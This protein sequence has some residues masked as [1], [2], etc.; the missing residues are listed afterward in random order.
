MLYDNVR[1]TQWEKCRAYE[2]MRKWPKHYSHTQAEIMEIIRKESQF[3]PR[4]KSCAS[5]RGLMQVTETAIK[6]LPDGHRY[7]VKRDGA[8]VLNYRKVYDPYWNLKLGCEFLRMCKKMA[9]PQKIGRFEFTR[10]EIAR[11]YYVMGYGRWND[12]VKT[13]LRYIQ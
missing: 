11:A 9:R 12:S 6:S 2:G 3:S 1:G 4:V 10:D 7:Y 13:T 8:N 5:A